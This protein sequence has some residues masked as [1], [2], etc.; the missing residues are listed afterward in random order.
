M[1]DHRDRTEGGAAGALVPPPPPPTHHKGKKLLPGTCYLASLCLVGHKAST[2]CLQFSL[3]A[4][5][6]LA[7]S[8]T[9]PLSLSTVLRQV[10]PGNKKYTEIEVKKQ[11]IF[12]NISFVGSFQK[13][14]IKL[15]LTTIS[16]CKVGSSSTERHKER[17]CTCN[18]H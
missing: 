6:T 8:R 2:E 11:N 7:S 3:L 4:A 15:F 10:V 17:A 12:D 18:C 13:L 9:V 5:A 14:V 1:S 16:I